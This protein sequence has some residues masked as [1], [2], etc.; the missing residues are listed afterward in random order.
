MKNG[1]WNFSHPKM[2][3]LTHPVRV[4]WGIAATQGIAATPGILVKDIS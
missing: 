3:I 4:D 1:V 2:V